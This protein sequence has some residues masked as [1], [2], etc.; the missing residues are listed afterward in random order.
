MPG[1]M[2][3]RGPPR[4]NIDG[5]NRGISKLQLLRCG[6]DYIR[7]LKA[8]VD[9]RDTEMSTLRREIQRL[10]S[11]IA[12]DVW[13]EGAEDID[14]EK[15]MDAGEV[16]PWKRGLSAFDEDEEENGD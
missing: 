4:G 12:E 11:L 16:G 6:N 13:R 5:P 10:R 15:N 2:P 8:Q 9:R 7:M 3:P 1:A 14:L